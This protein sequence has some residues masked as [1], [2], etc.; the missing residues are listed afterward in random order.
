MAA[1]VRT[2]APVG[3]GTCPGVRP[4]A[5]VQFP[6]ADGSTTLCTF[7][8]EF[9]DRQGNRYMGTAGHCLGETPK[10]PERTWK[11]G[12]GPTAQD[13]TGKRVG[14]AVYAVLDGTR[15][16]ALIRL[17]RRTKA[18]P[19][20]CH[21]GG[22]T[23]VYTGKSTSP[24]TLQFFGQGVGIGPILPARS[25]IAPET[26]DPNQLN[27]FGIATPGDSGSAV[28]TKDG[29]AAGTLVAIGANTSG[30][31]YVTRTPPQQARAAKVL[32][33]RLTLKRAALK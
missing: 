3:T 12:K 30:D 18:N 1:Q 23:G 28:E 10:R 31:V 9:T 21:F 27:A 25:L 5:L 16:F 20:M 33:L 6:N 8:F 11:P 14:R 17:D 7:G 26:T 24:V 29:K 4:G 32:K 2:A 19:Q 22:P 13:S 15:D